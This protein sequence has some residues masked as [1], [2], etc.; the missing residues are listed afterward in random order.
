MTRLYD[1]QITDLL[2]NDAKHDPHIK[3]LAYAVHHVTADRR[4]SRL[5]ERLEALPE[6]GVEKLLW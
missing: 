3:A 5:K 6:P 2:L 4:N 1:G